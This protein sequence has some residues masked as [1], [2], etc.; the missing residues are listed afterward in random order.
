MEEYK[1]S[2][3]YYQLS[4]EEQKKGNPTESTEYF[5]KALELQAKVASL[6][7]FAKQNPFETQFNNYKI[8]I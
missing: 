1:E 2:E 5:I 3:K 4:I 7:Q 8:I 6:D